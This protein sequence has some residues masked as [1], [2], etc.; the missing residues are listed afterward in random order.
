MSYEQHAATMQK[1]TDSNAY[2]LLA[3]TLKHR[4]TCTAVHEDAT[5]L[6]ATKATS[7][8]L[9]FGHDLSVYEGSST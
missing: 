4:P 6:F 2:C 3:H 7:D 9:G 5:R 1:Q 8:S